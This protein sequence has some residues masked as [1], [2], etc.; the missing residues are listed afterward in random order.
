MAELW[1]LIVRSNTFNFIVLLAILAVIWNKLNISEKLEFMRQEIA[2]FIEKSKQEKD[3]A[4][5]QLKTTKKDVEHLS[6]E[7][8]ETLEKAKISAQNVFDEIKQ[9]TKI[10]IEKIEANVDKIIDNET[11]K[12]NSKLTIETSQKAIDLAK[13]KLQKMFDENPQMHNTFIEQSIETL[14]KVK[15]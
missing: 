4:Q 3:N 10:G 8:N 6:E 5:K 2:D 1:D 15:L 13:E 11:R 12:I 14:D 9:M 7:I